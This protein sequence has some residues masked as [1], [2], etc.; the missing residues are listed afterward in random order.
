VSI[1]LAMILRLNLEGR[2][3]T[4]ALGFGLVLCLGAIVIRPNLRW[5]MLAALLVVP[6]VLA[7]AWRQFADDGSASFLVGAV[8]GIIAGGSRAV[9]RGP[10]RW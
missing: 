7:L 4:A 3:I 9:L 10:C 8:G 2:L 1:V 6:V 5:V